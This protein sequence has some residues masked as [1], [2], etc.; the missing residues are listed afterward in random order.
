MPKR[1]NCKAAGTARENQVKRQEEAAG[2]TVRRAPASIGEDDL[3]ALKP[4]ERP[5]LIQV[6]ANKGSPYK[7]FQPEERAALLA[8][9]ERAGAEAWLVHWPPHG[10]QR[11]IH[12]SAW[13]SAKLAA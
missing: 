3:L 10:K 7:N 4:G 5:R 13:P 9:A 6:K 11:W 2:W 12:S 8:A 1:K